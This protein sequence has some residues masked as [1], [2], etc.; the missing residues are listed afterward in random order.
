MTIPIS[1]R[2]GR[3]KRNWPGVYPNK[4]SQGQI[5][6][7]VVDL[8]LQNIPGE[9]KPKRVRFFHKTLQEA[10]TKA[11]QMRIARKNEGLSAISLPTVDRLDYERARQILSPLGM[12]LSQAAEFCRKHLQVIKQKAS[13]DVVVAELLAIKE[14]DG[15]SLRYLR[16]LRVRLNRFAGSE[17][18]KSR[19]IHDIEANEIDDWLRALAGGSV[20]RRNYRRLLSVLFSFALKR[21]YLLKNPVKDVEIPTVK[22]TKPGILSVAE[23]GALLE[24]A[25]PEFLPAIALGLFAGLRPES[26]IWRLSWENIN[27]EEG[28]IDV[29]HSKNTA[30]HRFV[31]IEPN[32]AS[33]LAPYSRNSGPICLVDEPYFRRVRETRGR[34]IAS[35]EAKG[36]PAGNLQVWPNDCLRHCYASYHCTQFGDSRK[37]SQEMG[38]S[39]DL[40]VFNY[41]YRNRVKPSDAQAY[42]QLVPVGNGH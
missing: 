11:E 41:H 10:Q 30:G 9:D 25:T 2:T 34:A 28:L 3:K 29:A 38:H 35:L 13:V 19:L 1:Q 15:R 4:N 26:E 6:S 20:N 8:G 36:L 21:N 37:T 32:L 27:L 40:T 31:K 7:Y 18:F 33:W 17:I 5:V 22:P 14:K 42:W 24:A 12:T 39:G 23:A 16:D